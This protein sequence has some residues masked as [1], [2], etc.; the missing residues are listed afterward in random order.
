MTRRRSCT[1]RRTIFNIGFS[2]LIVWTEMPFFTKTVDGLRKAFLEWCGFW[3]YVHNS[4]NQKGVGFIL[5]QNSMVGNSG[6]KWL[7]LL[8]PWAYILMVGD[9]GMGH[10]TEWRKVE[11]RS[12]ICSFYHKFFYDRS[13]I[14]SS[15]CCRNVFQTVQSEKFTAGFCT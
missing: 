2:R 1:A 8:E 12:A 10:R 9:E 13:D 15:T 3:Y 14:S 7:T 6:N 4:H 11:D 5:P